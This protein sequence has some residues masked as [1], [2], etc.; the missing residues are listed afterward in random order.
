MKW[1]NPAFLHHQRRHTC[2]SQHAV[3]NDLKLY[4]PHVLSHKVKYKQFPQKIISSVLN[5][6]IIKIWHLQTSNTHNK[7]CQFLVARRRT[8]LACGDSE[9]PSSVHSEHSPNSGVPKGVQASLVCHWKGLGHS[10]S[11]LNYSTCCLAFPSPSPPHCCWPSLLL[12]FE[13]E[14]QRYW[15]MRVG[16]AWCLISHHVVVISGHNFNALTQ[17]NCL[18]L[19]DNVIGTLFLPTFLPSSPWT[20][21]FSCILSSLILIKQLIDRCKSRLFKQVI[22]DG[23]EGRRVLWLHI[24]PSTHSLTESYKQYSSRTVLLSSFL[25]IT[26]ATNVSC[27]DSTLL[28]SSTS[29]APITPSTCIEDSCRTILQQNRTR[30]ST[31]S[32]SRYHCCHHHVCLLF[33][34]GATSTKGTPPTPLQKIMGTA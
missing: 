13:V 14:C 28:N 3:D 32:Y 33:D 2:R 18:L 19:S 20:L 4:L 15:I 30:N 10:L 16:A 23:G 9:V 29:T 34:W 5:H 24:Y 27:K 7:H 8:N 22:G 26:S 11:Q 1:L 31:N 17:S 25:P 21:P 6:K 12:H